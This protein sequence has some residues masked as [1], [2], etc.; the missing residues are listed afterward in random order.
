[1]V[2]G[3]EDKEVGEQE[4]AQWGLSLETLSRLSCAAVVDEMI[5]LRM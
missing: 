2:V 4:E 1:M 3:E 5:C